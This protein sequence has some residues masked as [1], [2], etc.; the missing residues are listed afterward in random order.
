MLLSF[1]IQ[2][3]CY[4]EGEIQEEWRKFGMQ[5][6]FMRWAAEQKTQAPLGVVNERLPLPGKLFN[7]SATALPLPGRYEQLQMCRPLYRRLQSMTYC[8]AL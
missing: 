8:V 6:T 3:I 2:D 7:K 1:H 4:L 5:P